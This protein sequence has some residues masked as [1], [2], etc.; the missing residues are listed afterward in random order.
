MSARGLR[1]WRLA[2]A[3]LILGAATAAV[4][5]ASGSGEAT[6]DERFRATRL[7]VRAVRRAIERF[8]LVNGRLPG[9]G[10]VRR[11][12]AQRPA[13]DPAA[14]ATVELCSPDPGGVPYL[15]ALPVNA[16]TG[17]NRLVTIPANI[18]VLEA[19]RSSD[20]GWI[21]VVRD[22]PAES[23]PQGAVLP[24]GSAR[25]AHGEREAVD[26]GLEVEDGRP[27]W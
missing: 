26:A 18:D 8:E 20:A 27:W 15:H 24:C 3:A 11:R 4:V 23:L 14:A 2:V 6:F 21:Y 17:S 25:E 7:G 5:V 12:G 16:F 10:R 22:R 19:A 1:G 13:R 9:M